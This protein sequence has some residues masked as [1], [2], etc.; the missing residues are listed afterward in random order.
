MRDTISSSYDE[1]FKPFEERMKSAGM[2]ELVIAQF[3]RNYYQLHAGGV[4]FVSRHEIDPLDEVPDLEGLGDYYQAGISALDKAVVIKLNGGLGTGM[5]MDRAKSLLEVKNGLTFLDIIARQVLHSRRSYGCRF[6][7]ILMNSAGTREESC[8]LLERYPSLK[9]SIPFD[10]LQHRVPKIEREGLTPVSWP[11]DPALEWCPPGHGDIYLALVTS[12]MLSLLLDQGF[13]YAFVSNADNLGAV[14]DIG[15]LGYC[16]SRGIPFLME[17]ADRTEA[18]RKGGHL[19][20]AKDGSLVLRELAQCPEDE[21]ELFQDISLYKYFNTNTLWINL[22]SLEKLLKEHGGMLPLPLIINSKTVDP[23]D[24]NSP[25]VYQLE[26]AMGS[27]IS[28]FSGAAAIRVPR[29][30]FAPVKSC[31]DLL[32]LWSDAY[33]LTEDAR[34]VQNPERKHG[35]III[36]LDSRYYRHID[37]LKARFSRGAPSL[38]GCEKLVVEGD[39]GFGADV[40]MRGTVCITNAGG[41]QLAVPDGRLLEGNIILQ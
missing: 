38:V 24:S 29:T 20:R 27:A 9:G 13:E 18:D 32:G 33:V 25:V 12:G 22:L 15:I 28:I 21:R 11:A 41:R 30:R 26:T 3:R 23:R 5:G 39:V 35:Q 4:G 16:A 34:V 2:D 7:L 31:T 37:Q 8:A 19:A 1:R 6:P 10:F 40:V 17:V 36:E 14:M